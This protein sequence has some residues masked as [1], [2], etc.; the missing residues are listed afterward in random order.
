MTETFYITTPIY[1][2]NARP[3]LGHIYTTLV[4]DTMTRYKRQR[5][6][7]A[8]F[9]TGTDE[10]GVNIERAAEARGIPVARHVDEIV[11]EFKGAFA[12]LGIEYDRWIR[13]TDAF[14]EGSVQKLWQALA[15]N[16]YIY[17]GSYEG[18]FCSY[19]NEFKEVEEGVVNP[20]CEVHDKPLDRISEESYFFRLSAM[21]GP[22]LELY[23]ARPDF[24]QPDARRNE[25][26]SFVAGGLKDLSIS[27]ASVKWGIP[28]PGDPTRTIYVWFD[29]LANYITALGWGNNVHH[30][31][32]RYWPG[33]H[34]VG[35]DILRFHAVYW[36]A[37][38][39]A[40][41]IEPPR[42]V[43]AHGM[44][45][46]GGRKMSKTLGNTIDIPILYKHFAP[47]MIRYFVLREMS[48]GQDGD[49]T[50][51]A[52]IDRVNSDLADGLGNLSSRILTMIRNYF[53]GRPPR[54]FVDQ[55]SNEFESGA[56]EVKAAVDVARV[57]F[58]DEFNAM[59]F[60]RALE[61]L[62][63]AI[64]RVDKY[65]TDSQP[66]KLAKDAAAGEPLEIVI[67]SAY[68]ALQHIVL[69]AAPVLPF[70]ALR[71]WNEMGHGGNPL[72]LN[73]ETLHWAK[74]LSGAKV[75]SVSPAFPKLIKEKIMEQI[76]QEKAEQAT[77]EAS[78][79]SARGAGPVAPAE[80][81]GQPTGEQVPGVLP[82]AA[83]IGI[84]DFV[85]VDLRVATVLEAERVPKADKLLRLIVDAGE[86]QP[87]QILAGI[88]M[89]YT[90]EQMIGKK[91]VV[92]ANLAPRKLRGF[93]S[94]GMLLAAS[95]GEEGRPVLATF[96][97]DVPNGARLK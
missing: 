62:W 30:E 66:W 15:D 25:V 82:L 70:T 9:L 27:R 89:Y 31:F 67:S 34:L 69:L 40:A 21:Q 6:V 50:Y 81:A 7:D 88:A 41:G 53:E 11:Q 65:I 47:D 56:L 64:A 23:E 45:L 76:E 3:H 32:E 68:E 44:W 39:L 1:Y 75:E 71:I 33:F 74:S 96:A 55:A 80:A 60:S 46:S 19:C 28:V 52:L 92:V 85:R 37:F 43:R 54:R 87:R 79:E 94:N 12:A 26:V 17:K 93:E 42:G 77:K 72:H 24:V 2:A 84:E 58:N 78:A 73:P 48:F 36:P 5:G 8:F 14:H 29:A 90:P 38:L 63:S 16:G 18:W 57:R 20:M 91:I 10:H 95:I 35:K 13:T 83:T 51:E 97:E 22:L 59:N 61:A 86:G 49:F 4:A